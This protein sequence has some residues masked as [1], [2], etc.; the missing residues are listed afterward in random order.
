MLM[1]RDGVVVS[2]GNLFFLVPDS[3][4]V[5]TQERNGFVRDVFGRLGEEA[6]SRSESS[7]RPVLGTAAAPARSRS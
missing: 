1:E 6:R 2:H 3:A 4:F 5:D 7:V